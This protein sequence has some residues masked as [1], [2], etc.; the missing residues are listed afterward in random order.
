M[1]IESI[2]IKNYRSFD[3]KGILIDLPDIKLPIS[4]VGHNNSGKSNLVRGLA[5]CMGVSRATPGSFDIN[6]F[7]AH[8]TTEEILIE[9]KVVDPLKSPNAFAQISEMPIF[10][11][12][13]S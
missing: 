5:M 10:R 12:W 9:A 2:K 8:K 6:D 3:D 13:N 11:L 1:R 7:Y 4:I